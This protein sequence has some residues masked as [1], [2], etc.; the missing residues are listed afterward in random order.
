MKK[1]LAKQLYGYAVCVVCVGAGIIFFCIGV[2]GAVK[3]AAPEFGMSQWEWKKVATFESFKTDWE[4]SEGSL[5]LSD[6]ELRTRW[7][8]KRT[9]AIRST[10]REGR[11]SLL[12]MF[13]CYAIVIPLFIVHWRLAKRV[14]LEQE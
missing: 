14:K 1:E 7:Q 9:I 8:D 13:I 2:Y 6:A 11:Q 4:K 3:L 12:G 5:E 10:R